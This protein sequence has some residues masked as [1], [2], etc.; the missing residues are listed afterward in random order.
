MSAGTATAI[1]LLLIV[2][3]TALAIGTFIWTRL[4]RDEEE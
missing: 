2:L 3:P 4:V 1:F